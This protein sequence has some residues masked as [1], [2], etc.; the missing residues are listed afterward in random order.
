MDCRPGLKRLWNEDR[1]ALTVLTVAAVIASIVWGGSTRPMGDS[2]SYRAAGRVIT[3]G[4]QHIT[5]RTP[6]YPLFMWI[7]GSLDSETTLLFATQLV[8]HIVSVVLVLV[9]TRRIGLPRLARLVVTILLVM[10]PV[11]VKVV[12]SGSE[13]LTEFLVVVS[14]WLF[15]GWLDS[16]SGRRLLA[17]GAVLGALTW[18]RPT[19]QLVWLPAAL[20]VWFIA[21]RSRSLSAGDNRR[22]SIR[23][24]ATVALPAILIVG[25]LIV[26]NGVRFGQWGTTPMLGWFLG[27]RTSAFVDEL[28]E[29]EPLRAMLVQER[30]RRLLLGAETDAENYQFGIKD[31]ISES[32]GLKDAQL[33]RRMLDLNV[34]LITSHPFD[35][36]TAVNRSLFNL[37]QMDAEPAASGPGRI[38]GWLQSATHFVLMAGFALSL[39][40]LPGLAL[41]GYLERPTLAILGYCVMMAG[42]VAVVSALV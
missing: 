40:T 29:S 18:V 24:A 9:V 32:T 7:T 10:P 21:A 41:A 23:A 17:L 8:L 19:F 35:Y 27:S 30:D 34:G 28:P 31:R 3:G 13:A 14:L 37:T 26:S 33:D 6:G 2:E 25:T 4:W 42:Y 1:W 39:L 15:V 38:G 16:R 5:D 22:G 12:Y 20:A 11:M 36:V